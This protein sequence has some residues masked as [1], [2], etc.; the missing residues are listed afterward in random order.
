MR[1]LLIFGTRPEAIKIAPVYQALRRRADAFNCR[2]CVTAQHRQLLDSVLSLFEIRPDHDLDVMTPNQSLEGLTAAVLDRLPPV[3]RAERPDLV[4]VQG[5]TTTAMAAAL[6][7][8]YQKVAVGHIEAGLRTATVGSPFPEEMN[9]RLVT[10]LASWHFAPTAR[11]RERLLREGVDERSIA[12]TGNTVIDALLWIVE[13]V[14]QAPAPGPVAHLDWSAGRRL[15]LI[16]GHRRENFG[17]PLRNVCAAF[18]RLAERNPEVDFLYPVHL[19]PNVRGPVGEILSG[20]PNF[21]LTEPL[22]YLAFVWCMN[23]SHL[24]ITDYGGVQEEA[25]SLGKPVLVTREETERW[26]GIEAGTAKLVGTDPERIVA[27][28]QAL[29]DD[30]ERYRAMSGAANPYGDGHAA[31]RILDFLAGMNA[32]M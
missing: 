18:R 20:L 13:K 32:R 30:P 19:N 11:A 17:E 12:V 25:P 28:A 24:I 31:E 14:K 3:I 2:V 16:T 27:E 22:D 15:V 21:H 10:R 4:L 9:R 29:L 23:R 5:D 1:I 6:C 8:H 26:E 7:A